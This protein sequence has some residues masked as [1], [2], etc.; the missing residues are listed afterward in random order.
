MENSLYCGFP[1]GRKRRGQ[2]SRYR[3]AGLGLAGLNNSV[4]LG[5]TG[6]PWLSGTWPWGLG[7][8]TD[9]GQV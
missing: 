9:S 8:W 7:R 4:A 6:H 3:E 5:H 1:R 2:G